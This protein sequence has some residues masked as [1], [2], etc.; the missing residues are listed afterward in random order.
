MSIRRVRVILLTSPSFRFQLYNVVQPLLFSPFNQ[1]YFGVHL[2]VCIITVLPL[3]LP[4]SLQRY[5][6]SYS[7]SYL[8]RICSLVC[9]RF[10]T[11]TAVKTS[12]SE[13]KSCKTEESEILIQSE[14]NED[15]QEDIM[16]QMEYTS[17][18]VETVTY[19]HLNII[20][21]PS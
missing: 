6:Q 20:F 10:Q 15:W 18:D 3:Y 14:R 17:A 16:I 19:F 4:Y 8:H 5:T 21:F 12:V 7:N 11:L 13:E 1:F 2:E 9:R